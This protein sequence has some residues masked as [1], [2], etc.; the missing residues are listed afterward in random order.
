MRLLKKGALMPGEVLLLENLRFYDEETKNDEAFAEKLAGSADVFINDAF[1][2]SHRAHASVEAITRFVPICAAGFLMK[3]E[4]T[5][6]NR[7]MQNPDRPLT[8]VYRRRQG[9]RQT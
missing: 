8:A 6:F 3:K 2:V 7:A 5:N 1:A 9:F 4:I